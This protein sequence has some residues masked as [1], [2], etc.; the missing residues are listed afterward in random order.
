LKILVLY[1]SPWW[2]AAA[3]YTFNVVKA[4]YQMDHK[5]FFVG[6]ADTP[7]AK[8][9]SRFEPNITD[10]DLF[11][12][13]PITLPKYYKQI[14][15]IIVENQIDVV[16]PV[17]APGHIFIG[18]IKKYSIKS[19]PVLKICLDNVPPV[20]NFFNRRLHNKLTNYF[21]FPG[22]ATKKRY[23]KIFRIENFKILHA[24]LDLKGFMNF[25]AKENTRKN[26][27]IPEDKIL[28]SFIGRFSPEKGIFFLLNI[29]N[30]LKQKSD[31]MYFLFSGQE[32]QIKHEE[33]IKKLDEKGLHDF[34]KI[35]NK[36]D[37]VRDLIS[38]TDIGLLSSRYSEFI[39]RIAMEFAAFKI[40]VVAPELN[41]IPEVVEHE[42]SGFIYELNNAK[43]A[44]EY[45]IVLA[46]DK[47]LRKNFGEN[48]FERISKVYSLEKFEKE[49]ENILTQ[50]I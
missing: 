48:G 29:V 30:E 9:I 47:E 36:V 4:L 8:E 35:I 39:C 46:E 32:G 3:Y 20:N 33:V 41:V 27:G 16:I 26:F 42:K 19:L 21:L 34:V 1:Q 31:K 37:D 23:D 15:K 6:K 11:T 17:S 24:P 40:P 2:N 25:S 10:I 22:H 28:V 50:L 12:Y 13:S 14:K 38:I 18:L 45:L 49:F 43:K 44:A 5:I 7:L